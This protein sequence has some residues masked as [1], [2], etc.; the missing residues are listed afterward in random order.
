MDR[1]AE[2]CEEIAKYPGRLRK[3]EVL[4]SYLR[5]LPDEDFVLAIR[6]LSDGPVA[7]GCV[8]F[9]YATLARVRSVSSV[10][11]SCRTLETI[12]IRLAVWDDDLPRGQA[13][14]AALHARFAGA[15]FAYQGGAVHD[16]RR[17]NY[18]ETQ[19]ASGTWL[20]AGDFHFRT[21]HS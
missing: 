20:L 8:G 9:P 14:A 15:Q 19:Q 11:T 3:V 6:F 7:E 13:A 5:T 1:F 21:S 18:V 12:E 16:V 2:V 4:Q 10:R 17:V